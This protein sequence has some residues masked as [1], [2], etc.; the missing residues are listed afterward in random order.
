MEA[1]GALQPHASQGDFRN[2]LKDNIA[3]LLP[4]VW[5]DASECVCGQ[6]RDSA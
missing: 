4:K 6:V 1:S 3:E 2:I 5:S